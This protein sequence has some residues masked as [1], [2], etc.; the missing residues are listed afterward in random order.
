MRNCLHV[1]SVAT[2]MLVCAYAPA[3]GFRK[4]EPNIEVKVVSKS[5]EPPVTYRISREVGRGRWIRTSSGAPGYV[6]RFYRVQLKDG[7]PISKRMIKEERQDPQPVVITLGSAGFSASRG[8]YVRHKVLS[9]VATGYPA[10]V[11]GTGRTCTGRRAAYGIVAVDPR[12]I[13]LNTLV[14]VEGYGLALACDTG[15]AIKGDRI[16]LCFDSTSAAD[17]FGTKRVRV[18]ILH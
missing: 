18:H 14:F 6:K 7:K 13:K 16:D 10:Y 3:A 8:S 1:V 9:M 15:G 2:A 12:V 4:Q 5:I 17:G 11:S